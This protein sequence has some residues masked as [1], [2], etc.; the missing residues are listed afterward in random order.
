MIAN[1]YAAPS[2]PAHGGGVRPYFAAQQGDVLVLSK[3]A[4]ALPAVC[5]KCGTTHD[6][7]RRNVKFQWTPMWARMMVVLCTIGGAIAMLVTT[8][9]A[10]L[11]I[12]LC[13]PCNA[14]WGQAFAALIGGVVALVLSLFSIQAL[15]QYGAILFFVVLAGFVGL[16]L[17]FVKPRMLQVHKIDDQNVELKGVH[18]E[19]ARAIA[20]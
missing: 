3:H 16:M 18:P 9:K 5:M 7:Q 6:M 14:R 20:G 10:Q 17:G 15:E 19:A 1:P 11:D 2:A 12:P 13:A 4:P 8:K